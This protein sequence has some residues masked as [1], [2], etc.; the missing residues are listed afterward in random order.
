MRPLRPLR[1]LAS[2][3]RASL[4]NPGISITGASLTDLWP[5]AGALDADPMH[6]STALRCVQIIAGTLAGLPLETRDADGEPVAVEPLTFADREDTAPRRTRFTGFDL[7]ELVVQCQTTQGFA[8]LPKIRRGGDQVVGLGY[9]DPRRVRTELDRSGELIFILDNS[10][11][12]LTRYDLLYLPS[13]LSLDGYRGISVVENVRRSFAVAAGA[14][15]AADRLMTNGLMLSGFISTA[16]TLTKGQSD[17]LKSAWRDRIGTGVDSVGEVGVMDGGATFQPLTLKPADAQFLETRRFQAGEIARIF[18][19]PGALLDLADGG[20]AGG[21][22]DL[23][24]TLTAFA[25]T[26]LKPDAQRLE[27]RLTR[28]LCPSGVTATF[29]FDG[30]L[31][32]NSSARATYYASGITNGWLTPNDIR[33]LESLPPVPWG[34]EPYLPNHLAAR[35]QELREKNGKADA[36]AE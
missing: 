15:R 31:R 5:Q 33:R 26:R 13:M 35:V 4:E 14:E 10:R 18:G 12:V 22:V 29:N 7:W 25:L 1:A 36:D 16:E 19:V 20:D 11:D 23:E 30:L 24:A 27:Q 21:G 8:V 6:L 17:K 9:L 34:N 2:Q 32:G 3:P 28:E